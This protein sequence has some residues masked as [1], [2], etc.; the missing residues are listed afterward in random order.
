MVLLACGGALG[1][2][3]ASAATDRERFDTR[4]FALVPEPR[5]PAQA[6][7]HPNRRVYEGTY[8]NPSGDSRPSRVFEYTRGRSLIDWF[9]V[10]GQDVSG[11]QGVQVATSD[12][13]GRLV[14]LDRTPARALILNPRNGNF[15]SFATFR[16][17]PPCPE[18]ETGRSCS[19]TG[20]DNPPVPNFAAWGPD[21]RLYVTDYQQGVVWRVPRRGGRAQVWLS[22]R[23]LDGDQFGTTGIELAGDR[24]TLLVAQQSSA[25]L[26]GGDPTTG[27]L[28]KV[29]IRRDGRPGEL[30]RLWESEPFDGP[31]GF[32]VARSGRIYITL[33][34]SN[35]IAVLSR[36][37]VERERFPEQP[38]TGENGSRI[39][40]DNPSSAAFL[41]RRLI[42]ANQSFAAGDPSHQAI[43]DVFAGERGLRELIPANAGGRRR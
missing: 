36:R 29:R 39:P 18:G 7:V 12:A 23:R 2:T 31:D 34:V 8:T 13:R 43:L 14:L 16:D 21:G 27:K 35:Q 20:S 40:F 19:P 22:D 5:Y 25:G 15:T 9:T 38:A 10:P 11:P 24:R 26:A 3:P 33:L 1:A 4:A 30:R 41:N 6:Y 37:G 17:L 42:V 28:Y 32:A